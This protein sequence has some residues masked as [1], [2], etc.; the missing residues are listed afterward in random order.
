[1]GQANNKNNYRYSIPVNTK[2]VSCIGE[3]LAIKKSPDE[4]KKFMKKRLKNEFTPSYFSEKFHM[5]D[6]GISHVSSLINLISLALKILPKI[7]SKPCLVIFL[8]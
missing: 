4:F 8:P 2:L 1:M 6:S 3:K 5:N 7:Y